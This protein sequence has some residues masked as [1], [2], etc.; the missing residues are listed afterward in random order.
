MVFLERGCS[1]GVLGCCVFGG[2][3]KKSSG[4]IGRG[5]RA[6]PVTDFHGGAFLGL[7][8][9]QES[10]RDRFYG[11]EDDTK[12]LVE[13]TCR[14]SFRFGVL[15]GDSGAGKT[16]LVTAGLMPRLRETGRLPLY[17]RSYKDPLAAL[18]E[19]CVR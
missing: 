4:V 15:Y 1:V 2:G 14:A 9:F 13:M 10:D 3:V 16:S 17:C 5:A 11:R 8:P 19:E 12:A 7:S 6:V 18:V